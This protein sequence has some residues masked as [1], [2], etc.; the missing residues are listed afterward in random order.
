MG[1]AYGNAKTVRNNNSSRFGKFIRIHF[2]P[3]AKIAGA[4]IESYLLEKS[5]VTYQQPG[6]ERNYHIFYFLLSGEYPDMCDKILLEGDPSKYFFINQG[7]LTV[8]SIDDKEE[9]RVMHECFH[10]LG[11]AEAEIDSVY[12]CSAAVVL[13]GS[14]TFKQKPRDEQADV[15]GTEEAEK[16]AHLMGINCGDM[17]KA[18][19]TPKVKVG[20]EMVAKG[21]NLEQVKFGVGAIA[22]SIFGRMF[23]WLVLKCNA[24]LDTKA[25]R[26]YF[27]GVLDIAGFEIFEF[28]TF[29]Q[30]CIN[31]TNER[32]QQFFNHHM[33][34]L[35]QEEYKKEGVQW[36]FIDFGMDLQACIDLIEKPLGILSI[37]EEECMFP[38]ATNQS[39]K[40]KLYENHLGK[41]KHFGKPKV[42]KSSRYEAHFELYHY[43]G[44]VQYNADGWLDKNKDPINV[45]VV[46]CL[47]KSEEPI[48][49]IFFPPAVA[50]E[51]GGGK[52]K[53]GGG[54]FQT[55][56]GVHKESLGRLMATLY[57]THPHFVRCI[58]PNEMKKSGAV[59]ANLILG[60]LRCNG[61]LEGIR[62][63]R[64]GFPNRIMYPE[65]K[66]RYAVLGANAICGATDPKIV[67]ERT[68]AGGIE[69]DPD[70]YRIGYTKV[71]FRAGILGGL[72][73]M[74]EERIDRI[75]A[76]F[77]GMVRMVR[78]KKGL[79]KMKLQRFALMCI[80]RN[81]RKW[82]LL[83]DCRWY[84]LFGKLRP[85]LNCVKAADEMLKAAEELDKKKKELEG[86]LGI[87]GQLES[88]Q[89]E[90]LKAKNEMEEKLLAAQEMHRNAGEAIAKLEAQRND[91]DTTVTDLEARL[92]KEEGSTKHLSSAKKQLTET[93]ENLKKDLTDLETKYAKC[94][95][96]KAAKDGQIATL[97]EEFTRQE[98]LITKLQ[99]DKKRIGRTKEDTEENLAEQEDKT[100]HYTKVK[101]KL[102]RGIDEMEETLERERKLHADV[103]K[104][105][106]KIENDLKMTQETVE[107]LERLKLELEETVRRKENE[108]TETNSKLEDEGALIAQL[109]KKIK[110][111]QTRIEELEEELEAE[112]VGRGKA[113][114]T[115]TDLQHEL[116]ELSE[117]LDEAG[118]ATS[119]QMDLNKKR[120]AELYNLRHDM[121]EQ[122]LTGEANLN[123]LKKKR[124]DACAELSDN[125]DKL[126]KSKQKIEKEKDSLKTELKGLQAQIVYISKGKGNSEK[127]A[128]SLELQ[129]SDA[130]L[131]QEESNRK[132]QEMTNQKGRL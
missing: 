11:F 15:D 26:Q 110:E 52:K 60:Q 71:F 65:F 79:K 21:Q 8:D 81:L 111:L 112:K 131:K 17:L 129:L 100:N 36:T 41:N 56:S 127:L 78:T 106:K 37:L 19:L 14:M 118:G 1:E 35:E 59:D 6:I 77:T 113:E 2:N 55:I 96:D 63:C 50:E 88:Q 57:K 87:K 9:M 12:K 16:T 103:D 66:A 121:E 42:S 117:K 4:D 45:T 95:D 32:L 44:V 107:E 25:K 5:R 115:R 49:K 90:L 30:L 74:R 128:K 92:A 67:S 84:D 130:M 86:V 24:T 75:M 101:Q 27:I 34:V 89:A 85:N 105:R 68:L 91:L 47:S 64:K 82:F 116:E 70:K 40:D 73:D 93:I 31:Y 7:C 108:F 125:L 10:T 46:D 23:D 20:N 62:I 119:A 99:K 69:L 76:L 97:E 22:K 38:K 48:V 104:V 126:Q 33:F 3:D 54:A 102:E 61:V 58:I 72:E 132:I 51:E 120:E 83:K 13:W 28:N 80:Q 109:K 122:Q 114:K 94:E 39:F 98:E 29:E 53:K 43:A 18:I 124:E 123:A